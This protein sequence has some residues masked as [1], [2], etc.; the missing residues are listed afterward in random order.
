MGGSEGARRVLVWSVIGV[1]ILG[2]SGAWAQ[3]P[4]VT[5]QPSQS[6][7][8]SNLQL[9]APWL[10]PGE[11]TGTAGLSPWVASTPLRLSLQ[12]AIRPIAGGFS[13]CASLEEPSGNTVNG[14]PVQRFASIRLA[15]A[16]VLQGFSSAGCPV[17]GALGGGLT[18]TISIRPSL[19]LV[20]GA[21]AY[22][23]PAHSPYPARVA[24]DA[25]IDLMKG[26][27]G[28][29]TLSIG[30]GKRGISFGGAW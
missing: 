23:V 5:W 24:N 15:P 19:S 30:I 25:R 3:G 18:Y 29:G 8:V 20:V 12:G 28:G 17:D 11:P 13:N 22:G 7:L 6:A 26:V 10:L 27:D 14:F 4:A 1:G 2:A 16:L 9:T 21:G